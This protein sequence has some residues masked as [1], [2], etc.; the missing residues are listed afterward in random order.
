[1]QIVDNSICITLLSE[2]KDYEESA[3]SKCFWLLLDASVKAEVIQ[4]LLLI[5]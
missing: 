3:M 4:I 2:N 5:L 1:M